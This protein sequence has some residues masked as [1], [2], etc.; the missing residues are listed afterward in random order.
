MLIA[1]DRAIHDPKGPLIRITPPKKGE[2]K[3]KKKEKCNV[4]SQNAVCKA[5]ICK[6]LL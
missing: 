2:G 1:V 4:C 3:K 5:L 6:H